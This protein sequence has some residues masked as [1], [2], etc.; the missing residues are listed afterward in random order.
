MNDAEEV[1]NF[2]VTADAICI[3][4]LRRLQLPRDKGQ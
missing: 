2:P 3:A 1:V 4:V